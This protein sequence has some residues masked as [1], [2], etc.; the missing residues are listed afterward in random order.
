MSTEAT[1]PVVE[2]PAEAVPQVAGE[3]KLSKNELKRRMKAQKQA[4]EKAKKA[5]EKAK[6]AQEKAK[7]STE[8]EEENEDEIDPTKYFENR[9]AAIAKAEAAGEN[10]YPHKFQVTISIPEFIE[11]YSY[12]NNGDH[13]AD[14]TVCIAGRIMVKRSSGKK[15]VFYTLQGDGKSI[16]VMASVAEYTEG[17][18]AFQKINS[19]L[20]RGD[21]IGITGFPGKAKKGELS[22]FPHKIQ[23]LSPCLHMLP[24]AHTGLTNP[25]TRYRKRYL[26]LIMN[27]E[28][29]DK[30]Y[31]RTRIIKGVR[32]YLDNLGFLEVETPMMS[33]QAGGATAKPFITHHNDLNLDEY[34][35]IAPELY[36]KTLVIGGIDRVYELGRQF[37]NESMDMTHNPEFTTCE[38]Y[39]AYAD[40]ND[41]MT[42]TEDMIS[43]IV[44]EIKGSYVIE[45]H[46]DGLD[47]PPVKIDFTPP[48]RRISMVA[49]VEKQGNFTIP[50]PLESEEAYTCLFKKMKELG[51]EVT[52]PLTTA[53]ILDKLVE[54]YVECQCINPT[55]VCDQPELCSPLAKYHRSIPGLTERFELFVNCTELINA[56]TELNNPKV[57]RERFM[58]QAK[59]KA[60]GDD[61]AQML[62]EDFCTALEHGLPPTGGWG[63]GVD[64][65]TMFLTD[66]NNIKEV[67]LF[68]AMKPIEDN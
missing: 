9:V 17:P 68:P 42:M 37:R 65:L 41:I 47:Q 57:Q 35:R 36:L 25:E 7:N 63:L 45:Y 6:K 44:K 2:Q 29:R 54:H 51:L 18:D 31:T 28:N 46:A 13:V 27:L 24:K 20:K 5:E 15:L 59:D 4:E 64:R 56:Y 39:M 19:Q 50:K 3:E 55:F 1:E 49:E 8:E 33:M 60:K 58:Q 62:D 67:L 43:S 16:Q 52:P 34:L 10:W 22:I 21:I 30:F 12:L 66:S 32:R 61:E 11:K 48:W 40:Y 26:D 53:R 38:F 14:T 23:I